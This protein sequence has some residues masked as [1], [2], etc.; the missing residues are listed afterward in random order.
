MNVVSK[1]RD[2]IRNIIYTLSIIANSCIDMI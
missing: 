2:D 1:N